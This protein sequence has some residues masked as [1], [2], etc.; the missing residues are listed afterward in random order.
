MRLTAGTSIQ[1]NDTV[2]RQTMYDL[3]AQ[4]AHNEITQTDLSNDLVVTFVSGSP[5]VTTKPGQL[6]FDS[7]D[8]LMKV[9][10][11]EIEGTGCSIYLAFG[12]DRFDVAM[13]AAEP[14]PFGAAVQLV[15]D[16]RLAKLPPGPDALTAQSTDWQYEVAK[17]VGFNQQ[18]DARLHETTPSGAWFAC[19]VEGYVWC[20]YPVNKN[21]SG[22]WLA[23]SGGI[24]GSPYDTLVIND[25]SITANS[26]ISLIRGG[27]CRV[28]G[29]QPDGVG[30]KP[31]LVQ[32]LS[33]LD[34][35][36]TNWTRRIFYG[37][38]LGRPN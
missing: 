18:G 21:I 37:P 25:A 27:I 14:I 19:A 34:A 17:V 23:S 9:F 15:G 35:N 33:A 10:T 2:T 3:V 36:N 5:P 24:G 16:G 20:W 28:S 30:R 6:W 7:L 4:A 31:Y 29:A 22:V 32:C 38:R 11:D 1:L 26:G 13:L 12:P 8:Q